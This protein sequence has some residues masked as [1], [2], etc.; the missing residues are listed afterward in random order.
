MPNTVT[1]N[2]PRH[3]RNL[4]MDDGSKFTEDTT[5]QR[6][7]LYT[8]WRT[9]SMNT[10]LPLVEQ[11]ALA[12]ALGLTKPALRLFQLI[13]TKRKYYGWWATLQPCRTKSEMNARSKAFKELEHHGLV[14]RGAKKHTYML[15]PAF[16]I[17]DGDRVTELVEEWNDLEPKQPTLLKP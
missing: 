11:G 9:D 12:I 2:T 5:K 8:R 6:T 3:K 4:V 1:L 16:L 15:S 13:T 7:Y 10:T 14:K 17:P